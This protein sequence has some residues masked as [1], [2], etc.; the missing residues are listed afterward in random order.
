[1][2]LFQKVWQ[3]L[4]LKVLKYV[5]MTYQQLWQKQYSSLVR[6]DVQPWAASFGLRFLHLAP[7]RL[8]QVGA[9]QM[10]PGEMA[11]TGRHPRICFDVGHC[12]RAMPSITLP[13]TVTGITI[14]SLHNQEPTAQQGHVECKWEIRMNTKIWSENFSTTIPTGWLNHCSQDLPSI[15]GSSGAILQ[16]CQLDSS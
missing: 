12:L 1:M 4:L 3:N 8:R 6:H 2:Q 14:I 5:S 11:T 7:C 9:G 15:D 16:T 10:E 13:L